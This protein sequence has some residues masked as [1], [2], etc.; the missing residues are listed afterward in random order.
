MDGVKAHGYQK[1][2]LTKI[3]CFQLQIVKY[4]LATV[5]SMFV[6]EAA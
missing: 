2:Y 3:Q 5:K 4:K 6:P 1:Y